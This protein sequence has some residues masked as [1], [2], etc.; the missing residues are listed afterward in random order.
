[1]IITRTSLRLSLFGGNTDFP[2]YFLNY[3]GLCLTT[4]IDKYVDCI[5]KKRFDDMIYI[6]YSIK[7]KARNL[8]EIEHDLVREAMTLV[9]VKNGIEITFLSD[10]PSE[11]SGLGSS[12]AVVIGLLNA[13][14]TYLGEN[15]NAKQLA[16]EAIQIELDILNKHI[17]IQDQH[18]IVMG[19]FRA[20]EFTELGKVFG[21]KIDMSESIKEDFNN[22]LML[23]YTGTTRKTEDVLSSFD[24][25]KNKFLLDQNK[26]FASD[27]VRCLLKGDLKRFGKLLDIYW[28]MKKER[29]KKVS[30]S[31][32]DS[33]YAKAKKA[34]AFG[35]KIIGAGGGGFLLIVFP[36]NK[37][38]VIREALKDYKELP[39][40]FSESG[41]KVIFNNS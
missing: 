35:G 27:G 15:V 25:S 7:E 36:A 39:F 21:R 6:N 17:G 38:A 30:N 23:F 19:G 16:E 18:A 14:H 1:M 8:Q 11:G 20:I 4:T 3:G 34:G 9:G 29:I 10:I 28:E 13:L 40:R 12:S 24:I 33:M 37:R 31:E 26:I 5:V 41:S 32:I 22:S 2:E